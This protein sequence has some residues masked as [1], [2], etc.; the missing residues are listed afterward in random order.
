MS[1]SFS[2]C[3]IIQMFRCFALFLTPLFLY[4]QISGHGEF[5]PYETAEA[6]AV[7]SAILAQ[8]NPEGELLIGDTTLLF[9]HCLNSHG[10]RHV[11]SAIEDYKKMNQ[12]R[13]RLRPHFKWKRSYKLLSAEEQNSLR[14]SSGD[15]NWAF[16][17]GV[18]IH[19]F[20]AVG[21][22]PDKTIAFVEKDVSCGGMCG[23]GRPYIM[24]KVRGKWK[25][26]QQRPTMTSNPDGSRHVHGFGSCNWA[27]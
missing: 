17:N 24:Q 11:D 27:Y 19:H 6:Y 26:Y 5:R 8:E 18:K 21:F 16:P 14:S 25:P 4:L 3:E 22:S 7:Y 2:A 10:D 1:E 12:N 20:S 9:G 23:S 13:L 15:F